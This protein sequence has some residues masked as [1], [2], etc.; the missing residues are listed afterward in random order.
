M[1]RRSALTAAVASVLFLAATGAALADSGG[2]GT[3]PSEHAT[4]QMEDGSEMEGAGMGH[5]SH[6][7]EGGGEME[8]AGWGTARIRWRAAVR[9]RVRG[10]GTA[11]IRWRAA[12]R[13]RVRGWVTARIRWRAAVDG[14]CGDGHGSHEG[15]ATGVGDRPRAL[16]LGGF[17][18]ANVI[19]LLAA[20]VVRHRD[21]SRPGRAR[22]AAGGAR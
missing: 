19:V 5:G 18:L 22:A 21:R 1:T 4:H 6:Q 10:W 13:W 11:R 15:G 20:A 14:G 2:E 17:A 8:G 16:A 12:V 3:A 7:M 9:W